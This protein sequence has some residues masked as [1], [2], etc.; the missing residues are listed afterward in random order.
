MLETVDS[1]QLDTEESIKGEDMLLTQIDAFREKAKQLQNFIGA[2]EKRVKELEAQVKTKETRNAELMQ[3]QK[4]IEESQLKMAEKISAQLEA[5]FAPMTES[6]ASL[7]EELNSIKED[8]KANKEDLSEKIHTEDV[9]LY[10]NIQ[11]LLSE[12]DKTGRIIDEINAN[13]G[14]IK[15]Q[16]TILSVINILLTAGVIGLIAYLFM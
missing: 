6:L 15:V 5:K 8:A 16:V 11:D 3:Q 4:Q 10:R 1:K 2:K 7:T 9:T 12:Y 14:G 13:I